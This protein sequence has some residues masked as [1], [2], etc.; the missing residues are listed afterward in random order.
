MQFLK[1][2]FTYFNFIKHTHTHAYF[3]DLLSYVYTNIFFFIYVT[4][5]IR[6]SSQSQLYMNN[7]HYIILCTA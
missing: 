1:L 4:C 3:Y 7:F 6:S 2:K 5:F